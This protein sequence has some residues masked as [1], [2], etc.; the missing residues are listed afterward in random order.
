[1]VGDSIGEFCDSGGFQHEVGCAFHDGVFHFRRIVGRR[2]HDYGYV[3]YFP[4]GGAGVR[5][6]Y[7]WHSHV[8]YHEV[9]CEFRE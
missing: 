4:D 1:M 7:F 3:G 6:A 8:E 5:A 9:G 2:E